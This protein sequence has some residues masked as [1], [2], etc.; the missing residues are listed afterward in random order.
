MPAKNATKEEVNSYFRTYR[1]KNREKLRAYN[2]KYNK[3]WR[4]KYGYHNEKKTKR[5]F[6]IKER[7]R[8][9]LQ[10]AVKYGMVEKLPCK[11]CGINAQ[12]HH[13]DYMKPLEVVW[14]CPVHHAQLHKKPLIL[15]G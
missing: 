12:A 6:P 11:V 4:S 3:E 14:L 10:Y 1:E 13:D 15:K 8:K 9:L 7:A 2:R 5:K